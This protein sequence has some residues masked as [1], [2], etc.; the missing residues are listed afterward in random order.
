MSNTEQVLDVNVTSLNYDQLISSVNQKIMGNE[1]ANIIAINPEKIMTLQKDQKLK[2][3]INS[4]TF[5]IPDGIGIVFASK[6]NNGKISS[7]ITGV[8]LFIRLLELANEKQY[9]IFLYGAK[10]QVVEKAVGNIEKKYPNLTVAGYKD[11]YVKDQNELIEEINQSGAQLLF[12]ALGSPRQEYWIEENK[13]KLNVNIFQGVGGSF[14]VISGEVKRAPFL[15]R[16]TGLEWFYR[17]LSQPKRLR[18]QL[19]LPKFLIKV[20]FHTKRRH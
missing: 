19:A 20:L 4:A 16:K 8:D 3:L 14:D 12:V 13:S 7:R 2:N 5:T 9:K 17:L 18:R 6:L 10:K 1:Q 15:F 11:G